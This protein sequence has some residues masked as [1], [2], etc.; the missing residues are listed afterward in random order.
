MLFPHKETLAKWLKG[1]LGDRFGSEYTIVLHDITSAYF[2]GRC[3]S[4]SRTSKA[5]H[6]IIGSTADTCA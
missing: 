1:S 5:T 6:V 3:T 2:D 4:T